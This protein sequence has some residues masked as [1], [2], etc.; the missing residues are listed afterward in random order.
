MKIALLGDTHFGARGD[1]PAF[2]KH[3][4]RFYDECFFPYLEKNNIEHVIQ[5]G[6]VFDRRKF[7]NF[8]SLK[9]SKEYFF[10]RLNRDY[11]SWLLIGN[12][13]TYFKNTNDVN[14]PVLLLNEYDNITLV[15]H[16]YETGFD[17]LSIC[18]IPWICQENGIDCFNALQV[19]K[20]QIA[21]GH[22]EIEGFE[23]H[24]GAYCDDGIKPDIFSKFDQVYSGHFHTKSTRGNITYLGTPYEMTWSDWGDQKGFGVLDTSTRELEFVPNP[25]NMFHKIW[26]DDNNKNMDEIL[27][28]D[29]EQYK[30]TIVKVIITNKLNP[31]WFDMFIEKLEKVNPADLQ[32]VEDHLNLNLEDDQDIVNEAEDTLTILGKYVNQLDIKADK[33]RLENLL[34]SLYNQAL[35]ME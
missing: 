12:H 34:R 27:A 7:I 18:M 5:L 30:D 9:Q 33:S 17:G 2:H 3:F 10:D 8:N 31:V 14:S 13:D 16:P 23:M 19:T 1:S 25:F 15:T 20:A 29:L 22:F 21:L 35:S 6:D 4:K 28:I 24:K 32:I 26:Y 11:K